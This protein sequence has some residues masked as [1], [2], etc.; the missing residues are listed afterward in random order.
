MRPRQ[1][2]NSALHAWASAGLAII[3]FAISGGLY[4]QRGWADSGRPKGPALEDLEV[5]EASIAYKKAEPQKQPQKKK[6]APAPEVKPEGVSRDETKPVEPEKDE[7]SK[8]P[9]ETEPDWKK[10]QRENTD[11]EDLEVGKP[12]DDP[13]VFDPNAPAG[14]AEETKGDP[15]FQKLIADLREGWNYPQILQAEGVPVGCMRLEKD[16]SVSET[17]FEKKSGNSEL[18]DSVE[19]ALKALEKKRKDNPPPVPEK[20]LKHTTRWICFKFE[21]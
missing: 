21:V 12:V 19:R 4:Y 20:L 18:D 3:A 16:G 17:K 15:Y 8:K 13:G 6:R 10:F 7:P 9:E 5:I 2:N 1:E 14:W 11:D